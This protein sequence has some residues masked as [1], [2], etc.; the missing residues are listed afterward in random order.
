MTSSVKADGPH[1]N[2]R[3]RLLD[4][5]EKQLLDSGYL[6]ISTA[7]L[8]E[9]V[10]IQRPSLYHHFPGGKEQLYSEVALRMIDT[11][12]QRVAEALAVSDSLRPR[13]V[14]LAMLHTTDPRRSALEQCIYDATRHVSDDTR[15]LVSTRYV[16]DLL[17][18]VNGMMREAV[19][20]GE[21]RDQDPDFL[22]NTFFGMASAVQGIPEDVGMPPDKRGPRR[23]SARAAAERVVDLFLTGAAA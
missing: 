21:L 19:D 4:G 2:T 3:Q 17:A 16:E 10:G 7:A 1:G 9:E 14:A 6:G 15:T 13:L 22:M 20:S 18:P 11:D 5:F 8:A 12:A 23:R